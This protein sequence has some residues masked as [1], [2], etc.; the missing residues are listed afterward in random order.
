[1]AFTIPRLSLPAGEIRLKKSYLLATIT[2]AKRITSLFLH[3]LTLVPRACKSFLE[4]L[5]DLTL[6]PRVAHRAAMFVRNKSKS[7]NPTCPVFQFP[8]E[9]SQGWNS[10]REKLP[11]LAGKQ[12]QDNYIS[13]LMC[14][15]P[16]SQD[17]RIVDLY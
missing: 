10:S 8:V 16:G 4:K 1:M 9:I 2:Q 15:D 13:V 12:R 14:P 11:P 5:Q 6:G 17:G 7:P 3:A